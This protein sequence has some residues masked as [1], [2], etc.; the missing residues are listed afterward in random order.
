M[1]LGGLVQI[2]MPAVVLALEPMLGLQRALATTGL[3]GLVILL[4]VV[5]SSRP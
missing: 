4:A 2:T 5:R 1:T 3:A